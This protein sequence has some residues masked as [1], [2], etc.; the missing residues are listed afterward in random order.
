MQPSDT[1]SLATEEDFGKG[2]ITILPTV[3]AEARATARIV[4]KLVVCGHDAAAEVFRQVGATDTAELE[5]GLRV[6]A[7]T[8]VSRISGAARAVLTG[9]HLALNFMMRLCGIATHT[10][11]TVR[12]AGD[13]LRVVDTRKT[14]PLLR[15]LG[16]RAVR[17]GRGHNNRLAL[18]DGIP[19]K[20]NHIRAAG[21][22]AAAL[23]PM[24]TT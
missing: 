7:G 22:I 6:Q 4:A 8:V 16:R 15:A 2:D 3:S 14:T 9:E 11:N 10:S 18:F 24:L 23:G 21:S 17:V 20:E 19:I 13:R 5:E 12:M 1:A